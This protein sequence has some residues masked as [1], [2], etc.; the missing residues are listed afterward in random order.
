MAPSIDR[1]IGRPPS[2]A[3]LSLV[4]LCGTRRGRGTGPEPVVRSL[5]GFVSAS[6]DGLLRD[7]VLAGP[8]QSELEV[9]AEHAGCAFVEAA[10]ESDALRQALALAR[11]S[12]LLIL[13]AGHVPETGWVEAV[14][15]L[16]ASGQMAE[17]GFLLRASPD[18]A[19]ERFFPALAPAIGLIASRKICA[20]VKAPSFARL[21]KATRARPSQRINL[22][23]IM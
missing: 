20:S 15:E 12:D 5:S 23:R 22:R 2:S 7:A 16:L 11:G 8:P 1:R 17:R 21:V 18:T 3:R 6:V 10:S 13:H 9:I 4:L 14:G 19:A